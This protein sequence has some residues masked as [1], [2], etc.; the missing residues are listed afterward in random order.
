MARM[1]VWMIMSPKLF[2]ML[3]SL[4]RQVWAAKSK[5][6]TRI[7]HVRLLKYTSESFEEVQAQPDEVSIRDFLH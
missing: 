2:I 5:Y 3:K 4:N 6:N 1:N 7:I